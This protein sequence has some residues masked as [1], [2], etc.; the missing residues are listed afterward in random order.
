MPAVLVSYSAFNG[1]LVSSQRKL[2]AH[3]LD[4]RG[5]RRH[6]LEE[7]LR[8]TAALARRF[9][10]PFGGGE[11]AWWLGLLHDVGKA[12]C[13]WQ[14]RLLQ[15]ESV[16]GRVGVPHK[17]LGAKLAYERRLGRFALA[18]EGH[19]GGLTA[20]AELRDQL[21]SISPQERV[22]HAEA[23]A[24]VENL[25]PELADTDSVAIPEAWTANPLVSDMAVRLV[26]SA[27]CDA[28]FLDTAAHFAGDDEPRVQPDADFSE[29]QDRFERQRHKLIDGKRPT[30]INEIREQV[31]NECLRA[32]AKPQ[33]MFRLGA[34]TGV[35]K[36]IATGG[37]ALHHAAQ[38]GMRRIIVAVPFLTITEQN[39]DVYRSLIGDQ[40]LEHHSGIDF[41]QPGR[42]FKKLAAENWDAPFV[43]TT[44][45]RLFESLFDRRPAAM[46]R[47]HRLAGSVIVL[48]EVQAL[49]HQ[50]LVPILDGLR[51]LVDHFGASVVLSSAT[52]PDFWHLGPFK[53]LSAVDLVSKP[54]E[55]IERMRRVEFEW[56]TDPSPTLAEVAEEAVDHGT[57]LVVVSTTADAK[58]VFD[59]WRHQADGVAWHLSTRM[60]GA[61]RRRVLAAVRSRLRDG[62]PV[63]LVSTQLIEA[64]VDVDFPVVYRTLAPA[65]SLLQAAG[66]A[67]REG[68]LPGLGR[69][70][71]VD[72]PDAG[73]P[74]SYKRLQNA[75][76]V[77]FG[78]N[79][80]DP[81][82]L[83]ALADYYR[84]VYDDLNLQGRDAVG[85]CIQAARR[86]L[87]FR[88]VTLGPKDPITGVHDRRYAFRMIDEDGLNVV[89]PQAA[90]TEEERSGVEAVIERIRTGVR[91]DPGDVRRLQPYMT[92]VH[93]SALRQTG[94]LAQLTPI[95]G[96]VE[97]SGS[98][99]EWLGEYDQNTGILLDPRIEEF[100]C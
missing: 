86:R 18:I 100:V 78:K 60:C 37:F 67:N 22:R 83:E 84:T 55:L 66:R 44:M 11:I 27:L 65:D 63:L 54:A 68:K 50:M 6:L 95:L 2:W 20:P 33:G 45:V 99:A 39:A 43:V 12:C 53:D 85:Q 19:H 87:D 96:E 64:G 4:D 93:R 9:A 89:V 34:P 97:N 76:R 14:G 36:T 91:P 24:A 52:Q 10:E 74:P 16:K 46:R 59:V 79:K 40:V 62:L 98:V 48:D 8:G 71:I 69:V 30:R 49:P 82:S 92:S 42:K 5:D 90:E 15:V 3:S 41:D 38:H 35:G 88:A 17:L 32:S 81:D 21:R 75:T 80:A 61:H 58:T 73:R 23:L 72:P 13:E 51:A 70:I 94:V 47:L 57:A 28:D 26:F 1:G 29:L 77:H 31:Y 25:L 56:R 7:H